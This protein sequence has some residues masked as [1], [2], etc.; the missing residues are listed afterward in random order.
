MPSAHIEGGDPRP[1]YYPEDTGSLNLFKSNQTLP[2]AEET[3][4]IQLNEIINVENRKNIAAWPVRLTSSN[5]INFTRVNKIEAM[6]GRSHVTVK[7]ETSSNFTFTRGLSHVASV[8][9]T[10]VNFTCFRPEKLCDSEN[11]P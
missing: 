5:Y 8:S 7:V 9:F 11:Q 3:K 6:Y 2:S 1:V 10:R 4:T